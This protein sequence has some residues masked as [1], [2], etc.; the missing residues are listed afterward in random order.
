MRLF[1][2]C[3]NYVFSIDDSHQYQ[4]VGAVNILSNLLIQTDQQIRLCLHL[5]Y[6]QL[7]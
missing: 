5:F 7:H 4:Y 2:Y 1:P 6:L 3:L